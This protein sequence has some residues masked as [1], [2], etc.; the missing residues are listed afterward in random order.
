MQ[1]QANPFRAVT[2]YTEEGR[3]EGAWSCSST[4]MY[5]LQGWK[6]KNDTLTAKEVKQI[7]GSEEGKQLLTECYIYANSPQLQK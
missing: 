6:N 7:L 5:G 4:H 3:K 1:P 2:H